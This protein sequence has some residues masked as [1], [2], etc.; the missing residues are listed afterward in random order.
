M[1]SDAPLFGPFQ[2]VPYKIPHLVDFIY[3]YYDLML[4]DNGETTLDYI[5]G[6]I[7]DQASRSSPGPPGQLKLNWRSP[8]AV[9]LNMLVFKTP[10]FLRK[11][12]LRPYYSLFSKKMSNLATR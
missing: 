8:Q 9:E 5:K 3:A 12:V 11:W 7:L 2:V 1:A 10:F 4:A 6:D